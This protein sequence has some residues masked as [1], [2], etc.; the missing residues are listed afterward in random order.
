MSGASEAREALG[1]AL[2]Q[3]R[4]ALAAAIVSLREAD[5]A[6]RGAEDLTDA[7]AAMARFVL[8][9]EALEDAVGAAGRVARDAL[10]TTMW[11]TG[12]TGFRTEHYTVSVSEGRRGVIVTGDVPERFMRQ[13]A[14]T[15][16]KHAL[17]KALMAGEIVPGATLDNGGKPILTIRSNKK[18]AV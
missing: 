12:A 1:A 16:D 17:H 8:A 10:A 15:V 7:L 2:A 9:A 11:E 5:I 4:P 14:P 18:G 6:L 13:A 3:Q